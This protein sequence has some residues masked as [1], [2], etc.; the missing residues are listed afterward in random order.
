MRALIVLLARVAAIAVPA[1]GAT[2][3][4]RGAL[5]LP[6][7]TPRR[8]TAHGEDAAAELPALRRAR[9]V[10]PV[11]NGRIF[12][13]CG[14][15]QPANRLFMVTGP[16]YQTRGNHEPLGMFG[17]VWL[18]VRDAA[19]A[20][21]PSRTRT[22]TDVARAAA[23]RTDE[24]FADGSR[25]AT[26]DFAHAELPVIVRRARFSPGS[27][28][29][30]L[31]LRCD[32]AP[33]GPAVPATDLPDGRP[34]LRESYRKRDATFRLLAVALGDGARID[35]NTLDLGSASDATVLLITSRS[36]AEELD[37]LRSLLAADVDALQRSALTAWRDRLADAVEV[38]PDGPLRSHL[39]SVQKLVLAQRSEPH[40]GVAPM[41]S[42]KGV[43]A[44]D[45]NGPLRTFLWMGRH[46]LARDLLHY[47]RRAS[48]LHWHTHREYPL[49]LPVE[50]APELGAGEW[51]QTGT[52]RCEVPSWIAL[53]HAWLLDWTGDLD[54][55]REAWPYVL[56]NVTHQEASPGP[57]GPLQRFNGDE[58]YL[59][60]A[61]YSL[62]PQKG[63]WPNELPRASAWSLDSLVVWDAALRASA[64]MAESLGA[65]DP[66]RALAARAGE[67]R[68]SI[69]GSFWM[70]DEGRYAPALSPLTLAPHRAPFAPVDLRQAWLGTGPA[71]R[72]R[73]S[74][75]GTMALL[76]RP[77]GLCHT[78]PSVG[79]YIG[80][81]P[82]YWLAALAAIDHPL[83]WEIVDEVLATSSPAGAWAEVH[84][85]DGPSWGYGDG[86]LPN[87]M[88]PWESGLVMD[89][90]LRFLTGMEPDATG[91]A[92]T[93]RP[94]KPRDL[95]I[96]RLGPL[97]VGATRFELRYPPGET[98]D[99]EVVH[100]AGPALTI[101]GASLAP[102]ASLRI[103][104]AQPCAIPFPAAR[105]FDARLALPPGDRLIVTTL[106]TPALPAGDVLLDAGLPFR[107]EDL[108]SALFDDAGQRRYAT[109]V[110][111]PW[112]RRADR[113]TLKPSTFWDAPALRAAFA[114]LE[115]QGGRVERPAAQSD[116]LVCGPFPNPDSRGLFLEQRPLT[117]PFDP[118]ARFPV[119]GQDVEAR[120]WP[121]TTPDG[122]LDLH[123]PVGPQDE[124]CVFARTIVHSDRDRQATLLLGSDDGCRVWLG[125]QL[126]F[127]SIAHRHLTPD[128]FRIPIH[129]HAGDNVLIVGVED[130]F[131]G[132]GLAARVR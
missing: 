33:D 84:E 69:D 34:G 6:G 89:A 119:A 94:R 112:A 70:P 90:V 42:F 20:R 1:L 54:F 49:D 109:V 39:E 22:W 83:A 41:V 64:R 125:G 77:D 21:V 43:W 66:A 46:D 93:L 75:L 130:R 32:A 47:Y 59:H 57:H 95:A 115:R 23:V 116:W 76:Q 86:R 4:D 108:A 29:A 71:D 97:R 63:V 127:E 26:V 28:G 17:E 81:Q 58:T 53:Q 129:L 126:V 122:R 118:A 18:E 30:R 50:S 73:S 120:W 117:E 80:A 102:G 3:Q 105:G 52:D 27:P 107:P 85:A 10:V 19:G 123:L 110:L 103:P 31:A 124:V 15:G 44:R 37:A 132:F 9:G 7:S 88:R 2:T 35:G 98:G 68:A 128:E 5:D 24:D 16:Q 12:A 56:R 92:V 55:V 8:W 104:L 14:F 100:L 48:A 131:G 82:G 60:G 45:S 78:T 40:G 74:L 67:V 113:E 61:L 62:W 121:R 79:W 111:E 87:R 11:A 38:F 25:L 72:V 101:G 65:P 106:E 91:G 13:H 114:A 51:E 99:V 96:E 36:A